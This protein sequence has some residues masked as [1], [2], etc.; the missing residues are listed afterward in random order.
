M[1]TAAIFVRAPV[2]PLPVGTTVRIASSETNGSFCVCEMSTN[3][4]EGVSLH[5]H[6]RDEEFYYILEG[7]YEIRAGDECFAATAGAIVVIPPNVAHEFQNVGAVLARA[8]MIFRPGGFDEMLFE[9]RRAAAAG[10]TGE[11]QRS[12]IQ[13]KWGVSFL[14]PKQ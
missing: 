7:T 9:I 3:P 4:G 1:T 6:D 14:Q 2:S 11:A 5:V 10:L 8:L 13:S 12:A